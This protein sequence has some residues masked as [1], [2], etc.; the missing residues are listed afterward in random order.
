[1]C[2]KQ[3]ICHFWHLAA[4]P[5]LETTLGDEPSDRIQ[6]R[7]QNIKLNRN[8]RST[9]RFLISDR[10]LSVYKLWCLHLMISWCP[11]SVRS[12]PGPAGSLHTLAHY[13]H[14]QPC[15]LIGQQR[16]TLASH[17]S[18]DDILASDWSV[19]TPVVT[20]TLVTRGWWLTDMCHQDELTGH[21]VSLLPHWPLSFSWVRGILIGWIFT[22][23][24]EN[25]ERVDLFCGA[26]QCN[27]WDVKL[28]YF[29]LWCMNHYVLIL[30]RVNLN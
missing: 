7:S 15:P 3:K 16:A 5:C 30:N 19:V 4:L 12:W 22:D 6:I 23:N 26:L 17:W 25:F 9:V 14:P 24:D 28:F 13:P 29:F 27:N 8:S 21:C 20:L 2:I 18:L 1:M 11:V 10:V